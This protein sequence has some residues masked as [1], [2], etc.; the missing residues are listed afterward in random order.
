[1]LSLYQYAP[2]VHKADLSW[3]AD[4]VFAVSF[5]GVRAE[6]TKEALECY[7][8][9]ARRAREAAAACSRAWGTEF[10][11][12]E[13]AVDHA[14]ARFGRRT[15]LAIGS[16]LAWTP[17]GLHLAGR[18]R[19][20]MLEDRRYLPEAERALCRRDMPRFGRTV[21]LSHAASNNYLWNIVPQ[22]DFLQRSATRL[23]ALG[24][25]GF[26]AGFGGAVLAVVTADHAAAFVQR[27]RRSY[28][29]SHPDESA[30]A[31]FFTAVPADGIRFWDG[32]WSGRW[33][34]RAFKER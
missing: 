29:E 20:F 10:P 32:E 9:A 21:S 15:R 27:W 18:V 19:Q 11:H 4:H 24:A 14:E 12:L 16:V 28:A 25:S 17:G 22:V 34:D 30:G 3:P 31:D 6:K 7:N 8:L 1:M 5:S 13:A 33:V 2:T 23:G 26:G